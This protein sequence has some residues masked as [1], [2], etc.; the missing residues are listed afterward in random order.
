MSILKSRTQVHICVGAGG[1]GKTSISA[2]LGLH[3]ARMGKKV[4]VITIDPAKRLLDA[5]GLKA[6]EG[7]PAKVELD[8]FK[9]ELSAFMPD[10]H[11]EWMDFLK[12]SI[13]ENDKVHDI[14]QNHFYRYMAEGFPGSMEIIC[15]HILYRLLDAKRYEIL[16]LDTPPSTNSLAFFEIPQKLTKLLEGSIFQLLMRRRSSIF[17]SI[18]KKLAFFSSSFLHKTLEKIVGS[19]FLSETIDFALSIDALYEPLYKRAKAMERLLLDSKTQWHLVL[20]PTSSSVLDSLHFGTA[21]KERGINLNQLIINQA[22]P[23]FSVGKKHAKPLQHIIHKYEQ[24]LAYEE[25]LIEKAKKAFPQSEY[26]KIFFSYEGNTLMNILKKMLNDY[27]K[28]E[29]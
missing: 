5:L 26:R 22:M 3:Y 25:N 13:S 4:L 11:Q 21:L 28:D 16:I 23:V 2:M 29:Y 15:C 7:K 18:S 1:V 14:S 6:Y 24:Q 20:R 8:G 12:A 17:F 10:L 27:E 9:G 19:H